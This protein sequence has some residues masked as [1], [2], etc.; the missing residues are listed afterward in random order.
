MK[1]SI[2]QM[3]RIKTMELTPGMITAQPVCTRSGQ[4][5]VDSMVSLTL[6]YINRIKCY[7]ISEITIIESYEEN[8]K[9]HSIAYHKDIRSTIEQKHFEQTCAE[10]ISF[11]KTYINGILLRGDLK[12]RPEILNQTIDLLKHYDEIIPISEMLHSLRRVDNA[13][14]THSLNV[15]ILCRLMGTWLHFSQEDIDILT[16]CGLLHDIGKSKVPKEILL[17][18]EKLTDEEYAVMKQHSLF[19]YEILKSLPIDSRIKR[20]ALMH[21]ECG[22]GLGYP[23]GLIRED[24]D[25]FS[26]IVSIADVYDAMTTKRCYRDAIC[27]FEVIDTF[28]QE[29]FDKYNAEYANVFLNHIVDTYMNYNV[30]LNNGRSGKIVLKNKENLARP[31][32]YLPSKEFLDLSQHPELSIHQ[33]I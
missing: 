14:Y 13:T 27:P 8:N 22:D 33:I 6:Q 25:P 15:G 12:E 23:L 10:N 29:G 24:I 11:L 28:E 26:L 3:K 1:G 30:V 31:T 17:K 32:I 21:H 2:P 20:S 4:V 7:R 5:I 16:I 19:G 9:K 18:P